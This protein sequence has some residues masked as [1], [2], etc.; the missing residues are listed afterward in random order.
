MTLVALG[1]ID[2]HD[3]SQ[4]STMNQKRGPVIQAELHYVVTQIK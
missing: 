2:A 4:D 3:S 1:L